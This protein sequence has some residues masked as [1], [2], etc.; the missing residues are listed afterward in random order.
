[1]RNSTR[2]AKAALAATAVVLGFSGLAACSSGGSSSQSSGP[3]TIDVVSNFT[4]DIARGQVLNSLIKQ[5]N[6][7]HK[8]KITVV[9]QTTA[10]WPSLQ[11]KIR[12]E[13][14]VGDAP[15]VFL[16]NF[17]PSD[18]SLEKY[19]ASK[20]INW[21]P[22]LNADPAW[23]AEFSSQDLSN[24][25]FSGDTVAI[26]DDQSSAVFY[27]RKDL[28]KKAGISSFPT[29]WAQFWADCVKLQQAGITPIA[30]ETADDA[31]YG[32]NALSYLAISDG[33]TNAYYATKLQTAPMV[34]AAASLKKLFT[35]APKNA[36]GANYAVASADFLDGNAAMVIDGPWLISSIQQD[37]KN[38]CTNVGVAAGP[39][40]GGA[41]D[42][43]GTLVT[44]ALTVWGAAAS[45]NQTE[46]QA[47]VDWMKFYTSTP[48]A[49]QMATTG[50]F[51]LLM[52]TPTTG[53]AFSS[54]NCL[55]KQEVDLSNN[56]PAKVVNAERYMTTEAQTQ[57]P[58]L[59]EG[60][61]EGS[62]SPQ[63]FVSTLQQLNT[64]AP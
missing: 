7:E 1:M 28:F 2:K 5:F 58:S 36:V 8:G 19:G 52:K 16:Y 32:M 34:A 24:L 44:D 37:I 57:L 6:A 39:T 48:S 25:T 29:T 40:S 14:G 13:I 53:S 3:V 11:S 51:P 62:I 55:I 17:N 21:T 12:T 42:Q 45:P 35:Y 22:Y 15:D 20:L 27:Y 56:A 30:L 54:S 38:S 63:K 4:S 10:D 18:T 47:V 9:S 50:Q 60:L 31:W 23:K 59:I 46:Q 43:P 33:G 61:A 49:T 64:T 41:N 26:P